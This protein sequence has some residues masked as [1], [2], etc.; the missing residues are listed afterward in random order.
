MKREASFTV[1]GFASW[2]TLLADGLSVN[3][4]AFRAAL[5]TSSLLSQVN[6]ALPALQA[7]LV[8]RTGTLAAGGITLLASHGVHIFKMTEDEK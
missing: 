8:S 5:K 6:K 7:V 3:M 1:T 2:V 4:V